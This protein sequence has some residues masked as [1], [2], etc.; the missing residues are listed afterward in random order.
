MVL[1][2]FPTPGSVVVYSGMVPWRWAGRSFR[3]GLDN[4]GGRDY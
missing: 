4:D 2:C 3:F 1:E